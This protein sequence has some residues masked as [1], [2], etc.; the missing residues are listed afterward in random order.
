MR[1]KDKENSDPETSSISCSDANLSQQIL[2]L[3][4][5]SHKL[6]RASCDRPHDR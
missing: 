5:C 3:G 4:G 2:G 6:E 1:R